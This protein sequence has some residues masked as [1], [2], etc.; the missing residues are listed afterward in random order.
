MSYTPSDHGSSYKLEAIQP[1]K[2]LIEQGKQQHIVG[3]V[4]PKMC[5]KALGTYTLNN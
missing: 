5:S 4:F 2:L 3:K 1:L